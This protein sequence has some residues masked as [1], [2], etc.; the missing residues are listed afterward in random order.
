MSADILP[1]HVERTVDG[2]VR[3]SD[4]RL[5]EKLGYIRVS[6]FRRL[7]RKHAKKLAEIAPLATHQVTAGWRMRWRQIRRRCWRLS[8]HDHQ[9]RFR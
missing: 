2:E 1:F 3:V 8:G 5:A 7:I 9:P 4:V 6:N